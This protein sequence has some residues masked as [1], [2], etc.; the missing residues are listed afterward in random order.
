MLMSIEKPATILI[1]KPAISYNKI[2]LCSFFYCDKYTRI[3]QLR[4][5]A[6]IDITELLNY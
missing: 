3:V 1:E 5:V 2:N 4:S 6:I